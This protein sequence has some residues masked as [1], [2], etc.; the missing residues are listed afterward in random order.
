MKFSKLNPFR[1][2]QPKGRSEWQAAANAA[3]LLLALEIGR[4]WDL[5]DDHGRVNAAKCED[6][7]ARANGMAIV[8]TTPG[9]A[10]PGGTR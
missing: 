10:G 6:I 3:N 5:V 7:L 1:S 4:T 2:R 8:P 9:P